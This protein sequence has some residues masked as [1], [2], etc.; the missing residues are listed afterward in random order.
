[1]SLTYADDRTVYFDPRRIKPGK[2]L[3]CAAPTTRISPRTIGARET[4]GFGRMRI[5][6]V[7]NVLMLCK[8]CDDRW[9]IA[10]WI[11][12]TLMFS[13]LWIPALMMWASF[14][15]HYL[16]DTAIVY[17]LAIS[18]P[19]AIASYIWAR[20]AFIQVHSID[21]DGTIGLRN[22]HPDTRDEIV[23]IGEADYLPSKSA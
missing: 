16:P 17:G 11:G 12:L 14:Q 15:H 18:F 7:S 23:R 19:V 5:R 22:V 21:E 8:R 1:M 2:C 6:H 9:G 3:K 4:A 10:S 13:P 20:R